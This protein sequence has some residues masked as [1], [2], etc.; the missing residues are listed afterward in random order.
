MSYKVVLT[1]HVFPEASLIE[2]ILAKVGSQLE[3]HECLEEEGLIEITRDA[4]AVLVERARITRR[5]I[6]N[7]E[8]CRI[9]VRHGVGFDTLD[10]EAATEAG[11]CVCNVTDYCTQEVADHAMA[12]LLALSRTLFLWDAEV[13]RGG[14][15]VFTDG[16]KNRR[17]EG[18]VLGLV[19]FGKIGQA[20]A[21]RAE[22]F[23]LQVVAYDPYIGAQA[24]EA[25]GVKKMELEELL[26]ISDMVSLH[27]PLS[28]QTR[29]LIN[30]DRIRLMKSTAFLVN[31]AR[32]GLV[33][34]QALGEALVEGRLAGA[35]LDTFEQEPPAAE[36][37]VRK[38]PNVILS[39]HAGFYSQGSLRELHV[40]MA[41]QVAQFLLRGERPNNLVNPAVLERLRKPL[42]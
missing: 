23:G 35:G 12:L 2:E 39:P 42:A 27:L 15:N 5:V 10:V 7:M 37:L 9:L 11:I 1:D 36:D 21:R 4:E 6:S 28:A 19:G 22:G 8:R 26:R 24:M 33:E 14:W 25:V 3:V 16:G 38:L 30:A 29:H 20:V 18:Q 32:G 41:E 13:R 17:I 40:R 31:T 34:Q